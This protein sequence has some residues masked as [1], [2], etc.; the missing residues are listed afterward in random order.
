[1]SSHAGLRI[2][3]RKS[4]LALW[5]AEHV[6]ALLR[7]AHPG[8]DIELVPISTLGDRIQDRSLAAIGGKGLFIKELEVAIS[9]LRHPIPGNAFLAC[10]PGYCAA[11]AAPSP[12]FGVP[13]ERLVQLWRRVVA[14]EPNTVIVADDP[15]EHR[16]V[17]IQHTPMLR[18]PD[19]V[20]AEFVALGPDRSSVA[21]YSRARYGRGDFGT[22]RK[23]V[24]AWL[25]QLHGGAAG[26]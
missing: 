11:D 1:M 14:T 26:Q 13:A 4:K 6:A 19:I 8:L 25:G 16:L 24:L 21:I 15:A 23:R 2:A 20:T 7:R 12:V 10:P 9:E 5:Q 22:N 18:F 17:V 3:T